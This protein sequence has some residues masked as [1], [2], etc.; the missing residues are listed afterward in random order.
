MGIKGCGQMQEPTLAPEQV[1]QRTDLLCNTSSDSHFT[2]QILLYLVN[3]TA[4]WPGLGHKDVVKRLKL[5][6]YPKANSGDNAYDSI[7]EDLFQ[8]R[9]DVG[10]NDLL[11]RLH[12]L[13]GKYRCGFESCSATVLVD[14]SSSKVLT[15]GTTFSPYIDAL[16]PIV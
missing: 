5:K 14:R 12:D 4:P 3:G 15:S 7:V 16:S 9:I 1:A 2:A 8:A 11:D 10:S 6:H 13:C